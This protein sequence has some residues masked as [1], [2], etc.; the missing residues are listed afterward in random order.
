MKQTMKTTL[1]AILLFFLL[2]PSLF[3]ENCAS[4]WQNG[5]PS[6]PNY[7]SFSCKLF[8]QYNSSEANFKI[9]YSTQ[10]GDQVSAN[11]KQ[12][13]LDA[14]Q[15]LKDAYSTYG[16]T[17]SHYTSRHLPSATIIFIGFNS[18]N[19][20]MLEY[21]R[22]FVKHA[23]A[24]E[25]CPIIIYDNLIHNNNSPISPAQF[26]QIVAHEYFH[27]TQYA[28]FPQQMYG[29][30]GDEASAISITNWWTEGSAEYYSNVVYPHT[31]FEYRNAKFYNPDIPIHKQSNPYSTA[32]FFQALEKFVPA[33]EMGLLFKSLPTSGGEDDQITS[34]RNFRMM[35]KYF[36]QFAKDMENQTIKDTGGG[37]GPT[38][39][40]HHYKSTHLI[41]KVK[42]QTISV[43]VTPWTIQNYLFKFP[44]EGYYR[45]HIP[46]L[47]GVQVSFRKKGSKKFEE[48]FYMFPKTVDTGCS[49]KDV[50]IEYLVTYTGSSSAPLPF[51]FEIEYEESPC[52]CNQATTGLDKCLVGTWTLDNQSIIDVAATTFGQDLINFTIFN[53]IYFTIHANQTI[54][55]QIEDWTL[56]YAI[57]P[58]MNMGNIPVTNIV[59][60]DISGIGGNVDNR[61]VC[62]KDM[63]GLVNIITQTQLGGHTSNG[64]AQFDASS[65]YSALHY[66]CQGNTL[67]VDTQLPVG[68]G[69]AMQ[70]ISIIFRK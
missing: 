48:F 13:M 10:N 60:G 33:N 70:D 7:T 20:N 4:K 25:A 63:V 46:Q 54:S 26:K 21:A 68:P 29:P 17:I 18:P 50:E 37:Y 44:T 28:L 1:L 8:K 42:Q 31:N 16:Q 49:T 45:I 23:Q 66:K 41:K 30:G 59:S 43:K 51:S 5:M 27:C 6:L 34:L 24:G 2:S 35:S 64:T 39:Y 15:A 11:K 14:I 61:T 67:N 47:D 69:G 3:A 65:Q 52:V 12:R 36:H 9:Y 38:V 40:H 55:L 19:N 56:S 32:P 53:P 57:D 22:T 62:L 58:G